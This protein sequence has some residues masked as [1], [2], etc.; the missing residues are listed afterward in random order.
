MNGLTIDAATCGAEKRSW[1]SSNCLQGLT[2]FDAA[3]MTTAKGSRGQ[4][5]RMDSIV[6]AASCDISVEV[7]V[8]AKQCS[9]TY[10]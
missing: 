7:F 9:R 4:R 5:S 1:A 6:V 10:V 8:G 3:M 2:V